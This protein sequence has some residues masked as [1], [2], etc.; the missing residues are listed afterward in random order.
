MTVTVHCQMFQWSPSDVKV[1]MNVCLEGAVVPTNND[2][3]RFSFGHLVVL[4]DFIPDSTR[5]GLLDL[6]TEKDWKATQNP[7]LAKWEKETCDQAGFPKTW[8]LKDECLAELAQGDHSALREIHARICKLYPEA[9][10]AHMPSESI[11]NTAVSSASPETDPNAVHENPHTQR[12]E[13]IPRNESE[14]PGM[15]NEHGTDINP[16]SVDCNAFVGNAPVYGDSFQWHVDADPSSFPPSQWVDTFGTYFI[17]E[18]GKPLF[19][20]LLL[21]LDKEWN[22]EW[23]A[24]TLFLDTPTDTGLFVRPKPCRAV[25]MDQDVLHRVSTP[26]KNAARPR[27]SLVWKLVFFAKSRGKTCCISK[28]EWGPPVYFGSANR[29]QTLRKSLAKKVER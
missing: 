7:P 15:E 18:P 5:Q 27:F 4:D 22:R 14:A 12:K 26:S 9:D 1:T 2:E 20:S 6:I 29:L 19:V 16:R 10:I 24:E 8:G 11:Q 13:P 23:D 3:V 28:P 17:G 21:Y 25:L